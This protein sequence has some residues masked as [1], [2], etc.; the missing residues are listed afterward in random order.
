MLSWVLAGSLTGFVA[1]QHLALELVC[2][3]EISC[4]LTL[5]AGPGDLRVPEWQILPQI[6]GKLGRG[7]RIQNKI[8]AQLRREATAR[9]LSG[10]QFGARNDENPRL[11]GPSLSL[12]ATTA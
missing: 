12:P 7:R 4:G 3:V 6:K 8:L 11:V 9:L 10:T 5:G 2:K 1:R